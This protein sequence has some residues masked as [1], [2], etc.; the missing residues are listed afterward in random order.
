M[1]L[2]AVTKVSKSPVRTRNVLLASSNAVARRFTD[3]LFKKDH[4]H[5]QLM[6]SEGGV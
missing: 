5:V 4:E 1:M 3:Q 2:R 6:G